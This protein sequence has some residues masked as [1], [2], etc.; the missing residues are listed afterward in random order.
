MTRRSVCGVDSRGK[1]R[2]FLLKFL[3]QLF[4][5]EA[6]LFSNWLFS[7]DQVGMDPAGYAN[8]SVPEL[9][10]GVLDAPLPPSMPFAG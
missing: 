9:F 3:K 6:G 10:S 8:I 2:L 5:S 7:I 1:R 4:G